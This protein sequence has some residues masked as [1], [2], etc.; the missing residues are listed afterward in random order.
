MWLIDIVSITLFDKFVDAM[1][2]NKNYLICIFMNINED[3]ENQDSQRE[4]ILPFAEFGV[5][6][7]M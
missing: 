6:Y 3:D 4:N 5:G 1:G 7:R 2:L